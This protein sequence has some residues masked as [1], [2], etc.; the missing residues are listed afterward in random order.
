VARVSN[1]HNAPSFPERVEGRDRL[2]LLE[3]AGQ[4][5]KPI[6][7]ARRGKRQ[8]ASVPASGTIKGRMIVENTS[9]LIE[10]RHPFKGIVVSH[11]GRRSL[12]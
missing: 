9:F 5:W 3:R 6:V 4:F 1:R 10:V 2:L 7:V 11:I 12:E 8:L